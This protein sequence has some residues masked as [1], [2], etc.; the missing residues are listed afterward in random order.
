[1]LSVT[2]KTYLSDTLAHPR[3]VMIKTLHTVVTNGAVR[4][5]RR[6]IK[7]AG[8]TVFNS[9]RDPINHYFFRSR[10]LEAWC[11]SSTNLHRC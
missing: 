4:A 1:M 3:A 7:H 11:L 9:D 5:T 8:I 6:A 10:E 2:Q